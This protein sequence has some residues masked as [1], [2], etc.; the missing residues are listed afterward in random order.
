MQTWKNEFLILY[1]IKSRYDSHANLQSFKKFLERCSS[2]GVAKHRLWIRGGVT[3]NEQVY[4]ELLH[5]CM[6]KNDVYL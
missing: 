2:K 1:I 5:L 4:S 3:E 6:V